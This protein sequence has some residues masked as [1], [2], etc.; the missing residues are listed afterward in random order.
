MNEV[1]GKLKEQWDIVTEIKKVVQLSKRG[2]NYVGLCP[3]HSEKTPSFYVSPAKKIFHC[4]GCGENGDVISFLMKHEHLS[5]KEV[6]AEKATELNIPH[7]F[8]QGEKGQ[9]GLDKLRDFL[10]ALQAQ[11]RQW[12]LANNDATLYLKQRS[13]EDG[14]VN[15]FGL[16]FAPKANIQMKW[17]TDNKWLEVSKGSGLFKEDGYPLLQ[18]RLIFPIHNSRGIIVG[19]SG[20]IIA[21]LQ[22]AKYINSPESPVFSKKKILY[23]THLAKS[24]IKKSQ[25]VIIVEGYMDVIAMHKNGLQNVVGVMG[26]ALTEGHAK[27]LARYTDNITLLFD[28]DKAGQD[29][30]V[31]SLTALLNNR[32]NIKIAQI[33]EKD[34]AE[35]FEQNNNDSMHHLIKNAPVYMDFFMNQY[36]NQGVLNDPTQKSKAVTFLGECLAKEKNKIIKDEYIKQ[37]A[38]TFSVSLNIVQSYALPKEVRQ[39]TKKVEI[40]TDSKF[41]KAEEVISFLL[42]TDKL[43]RDNN[44]DEL[45][46]LIPFLKDNEIFELFKKSTLVDYEIINQINHSEIKTF[47]VSLIIKFT[48]LNISFTQTEMEEYKRIL[49]QT[50]IEYRINEIRSLLGKAQGNQERELLIELS[51][52]IKKIK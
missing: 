25:S 26:T 5:F 36:I 13:L 1:V 10:T 19:F 18:D 49:N 9:S 6:V 27:E 12:L 40:K 34:P 16:G 30:I 31:K 3:F 32:L 51:G 38:E 14:E 46:E 20:R 42:I 17:L 45:R 41:K 22:L 50:K 2:Q 43:F 24:A 7:T 11:Y 44:L 33:S 15:S 4:F 35:F 48:E 37:I 47:L 28:S 29:A 52:L 8:S 39:I 21:D 23:A